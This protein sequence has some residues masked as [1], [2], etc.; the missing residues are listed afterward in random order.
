[1]N[2]RSKSKNYT[3]WN[4]TNNSTPRSSKQFG[5]L[6]LS[7]ITDN[8][9]CMRTT[10]K[11]SDVPSMIVKANLTTL[12]KI[13]HIGINSIMSLTMLKEGKFIFNIF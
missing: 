11:I 7:S 9:A 6:S 3:K 4:L 12:I 1:M 5:V 2:M 10:P 8:I 13:V